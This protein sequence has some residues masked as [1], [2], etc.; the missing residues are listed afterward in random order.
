MKTTSLMRGNRKHLAVLILISNLLTYLNYLLDWPLVKLANQRLPN[1]VDLKATLESIECAKS[2]DPSSSLN[3][4]YLTC[5]YIYGSP[6]LVFG[7]Y[8]SLPSSNTTF[9]AWVLLIF[10]SSLIGAI[11]YISINNFKKALIVISLIICSPAISLLFDRANIDII[12]FIL[13]ILSAWLY[14]RKQ[15]FLSITIIFGVT[16][17][18]FYTLFLL[19]ILVFL[20]INKKNY[21]ILIPITTI[22]ALSVVLDLAR[23]KKIPAGGRAQFG[24]GVFS[25]YFDEIGIYIDKVVWILIGMGITFSFTYLFTKTSHDHV[26]ILSPKFNFGSSSTSEIALGWS[27][28]IFLSCFLVGFNYDYRL[29]FLAFGGFLIFRLNN[30]TKKYLWVTVYFISLWGSIGIGLSFGGLSNKIQIVFALFQLIGD[31]S[32][33]LLAS[34]LSAYFLRS[35][36]ISSLK[37]Y[38]KS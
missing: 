32:I 9:Y 7:K 12:I 26:S 17:L 16:L 37:A 2:A 22:T 11:T 3:E 38:F 34:Y 36:N 28:L 14:A 10:S 4:L 20:H 31:I 23:I 1:F 30:A 27:S 6:L 25:W 15:F 24:T 13:V 21:Y 33:L 5:S 8:L 19:L 29:V 18:K 35:L